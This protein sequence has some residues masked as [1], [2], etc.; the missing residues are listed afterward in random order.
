MFIRSTGL[1]RTLLTCHVAK[2]EVTDIVPSTLE[3]PKGG[4][5]EPM[6]LLMT[7]QTTDPV[8]WTVRG[9]VEPGDL[10]RIL[11]AALRP[12]VILTGL[13]FLLS[14]GGSKKP[15]PE[16]AKAPAVAQPEPNRAGA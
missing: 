2:I 3:E 4:Q 15:S 11:K 6:R 1:G 12:S 10:R 14:G 5:K 13:K 9:F 7:I 8:N 16:T